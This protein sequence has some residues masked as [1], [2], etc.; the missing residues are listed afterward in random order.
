MRDHGEE[1]HVSVGIRR[2][3]GL[4]SARLP[5][6][7]SARRLL[8]FVI[9][10]TAASPRLGSIELSLPDRS[11]GRIMPQR[12]PRER[13]RSRPT[14]PWYFQVPMRSKLWICSALANQTQS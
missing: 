9:W 4:S 5:L 11:I 7:D 3:S 6:S 1:T 2:L 8:E 12:R 10:L 13:S 14:P